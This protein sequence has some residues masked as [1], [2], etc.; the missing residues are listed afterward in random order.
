MGRVAE[1]FGFHSRCHCQQV[2]RVGCFTA[3]SPTL[4][5]TT[6]GRRSPTPGAIGSSSPRT[7]IPLGILRRFVSME[8]SPPG[9]SLTCS[10]HSSS[11][12]RSGA[13]WSWKLRW[14]LLLLPM[15]IRSDRS[16]STGPMMKILNLI[17]NMNLLNLMMKFRFVRF[18]ILNKNGR[19]CSNVPVA[20]N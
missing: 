7:Q 1:A 12:R 13:G 18:A 11:R 9:T 2:H 16:P 8:R 4:T 14:W 17:L 20:S 19:N 5:A 6:V 10:D 3:T 15:I